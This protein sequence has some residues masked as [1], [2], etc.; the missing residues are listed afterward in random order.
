M[1]KA[2]QKPPNHQAVLLAFPGVQIIDIAGPAQAF[3]TA[4]EEGAAPLYG[5]QTVSFR[6]GLVRT[7]S[8]VEMEASALQAVEDID[9]LIVP[10]GPGVHEV[11]RD[12]ASIASLLEISK[13]AQRICAVCTGAFLLAEAGLLDGRKVVTHWRSCEQLAREF[14]EV[15]VDPEPLFIQDG[16]IWTTAGI[17]A[18]IDLVLA[19][20]EED[21]GAA[22]ATR[23]AR[24]LVVYMRRPGG[25]KQY[26]EP[27][28]LQSVSAAPYQRLIQQIANAPTAPWMIEHM[29][30]AAGQSPRTF[31]RKFAAATG[32]TPAEAVEKVRSELARTLIHT[33]DLRLDQIAERTGF[34]SETTLRRALIRQFGVGPRE[35]RER[36]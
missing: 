12:P 7:A 13:R 9:T 17:T 24:R 27:L 14:P 5:V 29:A 20:I 25:Q 36:F 18:G 34:R 3:T 28:A 4:N 15:K 16:A 10:G 22:L 21:H 30:S 8:G 31:H 35:M 23:V 1:S 6:A 2:G 33:T 19:L 11:R 32:Q 26:S